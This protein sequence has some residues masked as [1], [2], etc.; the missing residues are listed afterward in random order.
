MR[1]IFIIAHFFL[2]FFYYTSNMSKIEKINIQ[3]KNAKIKSQNINKICY[4]FSEDY[5]A[6][7]T[8]SIIGCSRQ[9]INHYYKILRE[10]ILKQNLLYDFRQIS[11]LIKQNCL[12]IKHFNIYNHDIFYTQT[13]YGIFIF[14]NQDV[15]PYKLIQFIKEDLQDKLSN[16]KKAN[17][18]RVLYNKEKGSYLISG[19]F[20]AQN[21]FEEFIINRLKK[22]RGINKNNFHTHLNECLFRY[23]NKNTDFYEKILETLCK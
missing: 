17:S 7:E 15:L 10:K 18:A 19:F 21:D 6:I 1:I 22:F 4:Y 14:E 8:A 16:H 13:I 20:K 12:E 11:S 9:T 2:T 5:T 3:I 23:N